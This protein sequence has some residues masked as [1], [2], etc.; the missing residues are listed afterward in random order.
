MEIFYSTLR[1]IHEKQQIPLPKE[2]ILGG[3]KMDLY[4]IYKLVTNSGGFHRVTTDRGWKRIS[5]CFN[6]S[7][8]CTNSAFVFKQLYKKHLLIYEL[9]V[10]M[11]LS[12]DDAISKLDLDMED[13]G[14]RKRSHLEENSGRFQVI[15][16]DQNKFQQNAMYFD[17]SSDGKLLIN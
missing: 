3:Q 8:T 17:D 7:S 15:S 2:A 14:D 4:K 12:V 11:N 10:K 1:E 13:G 6:L 9:M 5:D 16:K